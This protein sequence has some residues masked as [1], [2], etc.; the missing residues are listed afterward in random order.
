MEPPSAPSALLA[1][2]AQSHPTLQLHAQMAGTTL[3]MVRQ[4]VRGAQ[5]VSTVTQVPR[6]S[7]QSHVLQEP[8]QLSKEAR[9]ASPALR[10]TSVTRPPLSSVRMVSTHQQA[11]IGASLAHQATL[12][13]EPAMRERPRRFALMVTTPWL[14]SSTVVHVHLAMSAH[15]R[16]EDH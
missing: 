11:A 12:A 15:T 7:T 1:T 3:T 13:M 10:G 2:S 16:L 6:R 5:P 4:S 14:V 9:L 8:T